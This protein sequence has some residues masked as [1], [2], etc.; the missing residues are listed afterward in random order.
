[1]N[2]FKKRIMKKFL[3]VFDGY[4]MSVGF[5]GICH[6]AY[7]ISRFLTSQIEKIKKSVFE[8]GSEI[9]KYFEMLPDDCGLKQLYR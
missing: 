8:T 2:Y 3:V 9:A 4:K 1:M 6:S 5:L 7:E